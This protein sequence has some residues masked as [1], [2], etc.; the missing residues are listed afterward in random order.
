MAKRR[1]AR[2][3][4]IG[5][6]KFCVGGHTARRPLSV[7]GTTTG[8][9]RAHTK[10]RG[11]FNRIFSFFSIRDDRYS[12][13]VCVCTCVRVCLQGSISNGEKLRRGL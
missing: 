7:N 4:L 2:D 12:Y 5:G 3:I 9:R 8:K 10:N 13:R 6:H 1:G 11:K